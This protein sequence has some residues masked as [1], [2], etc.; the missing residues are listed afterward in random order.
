[1]LGHVSAG[2]MLFFACVSCQYVVCCSDNQQFLK[3][4]INSV[5]DGRGLGW[6]KGNRINKLMEDENYRNFVVSRLN[7]NLD[8]KVAEDAVHMEDVVSSLVQ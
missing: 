2:S 5:L 7:R 3:E 4:V 8:K 6:M 1:M